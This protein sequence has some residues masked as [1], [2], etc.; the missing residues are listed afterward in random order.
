MA[1]GC[2]QSASAGTTPISLVTSDGATRTATQLVPEGYDP[3]TPTAVVLNFHGLSSVGP[4]QHGYSGLPSVADR[5]N[6]VLVSPQGTSAPVFDQTYWNT[7]TGRRPVGFDGTLVDD[8]AYVAELLDDLT[9][10]LCI[11]P[12]RVHATGLSNGGFFSSRLACNLSDRIASIATV[13][14]V[15]DPTDCAQDRPVPVLAIHGTADPIVPFD[16][17]ESTI[18]DL[19]GLDTEDLFG[20]LVGTRE[21][22]PEIV[23]E[24]AE[25]NGCETAT[26]ARALSATVERRDYPGCTAATS[27]IVVEGGGHTWPGAEPRFASILGAT[28]PTVSA[29]ETVWEWFVENPRR[30]D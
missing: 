25:R 20:L 16:A 19:L 4:D 23:D 27:L 12:D 9:E 17:T 26:S 14:G 13:G 30:A 21:P 11:D 2:G 24:W 1:D 15:F 8:V 28:D 22:I 18:G 6:F 5:E 29:A 10:R 3:E 7:A